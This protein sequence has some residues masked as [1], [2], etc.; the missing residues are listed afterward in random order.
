LQLKERVPDATFGLAT[1]TDREATEPHWTNDLHRDR[2]ERLLLHPKY[3][4]NSDPKREDYIGLAFP[5]MVY[6]SKGWRGDYREARR[7]ATSAAAY[8]LDMLDQLVRKPG[9][10]E[11]LR[12]YQT[13]S[14]HQ[15]QVFALTSWGAYWHLLVGHRRPRLD[16]EHVNNPGMSDTVYVCST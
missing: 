2:L 7:Q 14:S 16:S 5:F 10:I 15:Y 3:G 4:L 1:F 9:P 11:S 6:E 8:Y 13:S 12:V